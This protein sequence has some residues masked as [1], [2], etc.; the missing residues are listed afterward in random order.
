M[1]KTTRPQGVV[2]TTKSPAAE[3]AA[4]LADLSKVTGKTPKLEKEQLALRFSAI[5]LATKA[6]PGVFKDDQFWLA[7][8]PELR[9][10]TFELLGVIILQALE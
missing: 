5:R 2:H 4:L 8:S 3:L 7:I 1:E 10:P 9:E 6:D